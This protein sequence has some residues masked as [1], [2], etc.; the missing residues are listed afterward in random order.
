M[1]PMFFADPA[2][3]PEA[4]AVAGPVLATAEAVPAAEDPAREVVHVRAEAA[5]R[6]AAPRPLGVV[7]L[8]AE[9]LALSPGQDLVQRPGKMALRVTIIE[10]I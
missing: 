5:V 4:E 8:I 7:V 10:S 6:R 9:R 3:V 1:L 2:A